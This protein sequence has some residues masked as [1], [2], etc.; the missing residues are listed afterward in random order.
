MRLRKRFSRIA[1]GL[2]CLFFISIASAGFTAHARQTDQQ[3]L[4]SGRSCQD[5]LFASSKKQ[6]HRNQWEKCI[7]FYER[8][9]TRYPKSPWV[10]DSLFILGGLYRGLSGYSGLSADREKSISYYRRLI[11]HFPDGPFVKK[12]RLRLKAL[13]SF[14]GVTV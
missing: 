7:L 14:S 11:R 12:T 1:I 6:K 10:D 2:G 9:V 3:L 13:G 4:E 5:R 8:L